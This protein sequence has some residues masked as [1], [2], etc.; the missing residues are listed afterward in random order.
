MGVTAGHL[1]ALTDAERVELATER[2]RLVWRAA[3]F[4]LAAPCVFV[5]VLVT[6]AIGA[7][8]LPVPGRI[9]WAFLAVGALI[10]MGV[11]ALKTL[12]LLRR[13]RRI[14][15]D[16]RRGEVACFEGGARAAVS[17]RTRI[18]LARENFPVDG[19]L[20]VA[21]ESLCG[22]GRLWSVGG[23]RSRSWMLLPL[24]TPAAM[25]E[26]ATVAANWVR[27]VASQGTATL[28]ART[29]LLSID[30]RA[31][32]AGLL[33]RSLRRT[34]R[35]AVGVVI[36]LGLVMPGSLRARSA[37]GLRLAGAT[38][39]ALVLLRFGRKLA[40]DLRLAR[41]LSRD[42][43]N[44]MVQIVRTRAREDAEMSPATEILPASRVAWTRGGE[45]VP[46]R[47]GSGAEIARG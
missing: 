16:L 27:P 35:E 20:S 43:A 32:I 19:A 34:M 2:G 30:E 36:T 11:L 33:R 7:P 21:F 28:L 1:R 39:C 4:G 17:E 40:R 23:V 14:A 38:L 25:P 10:V 45:P 18:I 9:L 8:M 44:G 29:R 15:A 6:A 46:W 47:R 31:E 13:R 37:M 26:H 41:A 3:L 42:R 12:D 22:S 5:G 24:Q